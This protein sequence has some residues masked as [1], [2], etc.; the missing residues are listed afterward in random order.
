VKTTI[1]VIA[2]KPFTIGDR[3]Y[4]PGEAV[5]LTP[6]DAV[7]YAKKR[8]VTLTRRKPVEP[9][10]AAEPEPAKPEPK[11]KRQYKRR[12]MEAEQTT[13]IDEIQASQGSDLA[14][15]LR[16]SDGARVAPVVVDM[17]DGE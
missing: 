16:T 9:P 8:L 6:I 3:T 2:L 15:A 12:D 4:G 17:G 11:P 10:K 13:A 1:Q 14:D 5:Q 7:S